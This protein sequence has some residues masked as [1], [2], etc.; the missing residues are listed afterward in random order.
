MNTSPLRDD[1]P[2]VAISLSANCCCCILRMEVA[3]LL[4][5]SASV[6]ALHHMHLCVRSRLITESS[7]PGSSARH[8]GVVDGWAHHD[9]MSPRLVSISRSLS[10]QTV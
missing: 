3:A 5:Y 1:R 6:P 9:E 10:G 8:Y 2:G 4:M 7:R